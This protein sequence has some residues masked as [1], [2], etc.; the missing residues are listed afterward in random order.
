[1]DNDHVAHILE[2]WGQ[3]CPELDTSSLAISGRIL[4]AADLLVERSQV[5][6]SR[7]GLPAGGVDVLAAL[8]RAGPPY[9]LSPTQLY[10]ELLISSGTI[11]YRLDRLERLGFIQRLPDPADRRGLIVQLTEAGRLCVNEALGEYLE[12]DRNLLSVLT[13]QERNDITHGLAK[14]LLSLE[15][16]TSQENDQRGTK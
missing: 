14:L 6:F 15:T 13:E 5:I 11:T 2:Q 3:T 8:W 12:N 9:Q 7:Y 10:R 1:M 4:L 16:P